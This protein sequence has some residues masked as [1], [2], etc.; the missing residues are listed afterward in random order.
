M[1]LIFGAGLFFIDF[2]K[3]FHPIWDWLF[4]VFA[5][6]WVL[7][8]V[9][10]LACLSTGFVLVRRILGKRLRSGELLALSMPMGIFVFAMA[11]FV[12]GLFGLYGPVLFV[13]LP[14][15]MFAVGARPLWRFARRWIRHRLAFR[16]RAVP[17]PWMYVAWGFGLVV[18]GM[19]YFLILSPANISF[20]SRWKHLAIAEHYATQGFVGPFLE[21]W[22]PGTAPHLPS[23]FFAWAFLVRPWADLFGQL[24][25]VAH[26]EFVLFLWTLVGIGPLVRR[27]VPRA[28]PRWVWVVR[29]LFP[30]MLLYD[31]NLSVG[32]DHIAAIFTIPI[33]LMTMRA[34]NG[35]RPRDCLVLAVM[36]SG[37]LLT[38]Y[39]SAFAL[40]AFPVVVVT[41]RGL[42]YL[43]HT[44]RRSRPDLARTAWIA[45]PL[46]CLVAG[47]VLTSPHWLK[48]WIWYGSPVYPSG[49]DLFTLRPWNPDAADIFRYG[50]LGQMWQPPATWA[51][52]LSALKVQFTFSLIPHDWAEFH[53]KRP[54]FGS[55]FTLALLCM[56]FV[57][58]TRWLWNLFACVHLGIFTWY[59]VHHQDRHLQTLMPLMA[60][61]TA[62]IFI[63]VWRAGRPARV[64]LLFA[65]ALQVI[66]G[67]DVWFFPTHNMAKT[68]IVASAEL[69]GSSW[70]KKRDQRL[71]TF[72]GIAKVREALPKGAKV[73]L[74]D[75]HPHT[76]IGAPSVSDHQGWQ[77]GINYGRLEAPGA[78]YDR[79][80]EMGVTHLLWVHRNSRG[81]DS[82][83]GDVAFWNF[84]LGYGKNPKRY[85]EY[86]L[87]EMPDERPSDPA[88]SDILVLSCDETYRTGVYDLDQLTVLAFGK[89]AP[90]WPEPKRP[91]D[92]TQRVS[93]RQHAFVLLEEGCGNLPARERSAFEHAATRRRREHIPLAREPR[94]HKWEIWR[95]TK[96]APEPRPTTSSS[97]FRHRP[98][99]GAAP[100]SPEM[101]RPLIRGGAPGPLAPNR[102]P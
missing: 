86:V 47:L 11:M 64:A 48:N 76:G 49:S 96:P 32:T 62:A 10:A 18:L 16:R 63:L 29:F 17:S 50:Y 88:P 70:T 37:G 59:W 57:R 72:T 61:G 54:V 26:M 79:L 68:P 78:I 102:Q 21:G 8:L 43:F 23:F 73:L 13:A 20:D 81:W 4:W 91:W 53:G 83:A 99:E 5:Q 93:Y 15:A 94:H 82:L 7:S 90:E 28:D 66:W 77:S 27:L 71:R 40:F 22:T 89:D 38:K 58:S 51:G 42:I 75:I 67:G 6:A 25:L 3:I 87:A 95:R 39:S 19:A 69:L 98:V 9:F 101:L 2:T 55:L 74:H 97:G 85:N 30:G 41:L 35:L 1:T 31:S 14:A 52:L 60:A 46:T 12:L 44:L 80:R 24:A 56:P 84:A 36:L 33:F 34:W 65:I 92:A 100:S 45:G